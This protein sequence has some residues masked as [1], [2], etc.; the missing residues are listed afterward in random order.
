[1]DRSIGVE[2]DEVG[3]DVDHV[4]GVAV[5]FGDVLTFRGDELE[6]PAVRR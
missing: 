1:V 2:F 3:R 5:P 6:A 4:P